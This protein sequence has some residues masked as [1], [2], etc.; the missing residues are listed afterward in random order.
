[1][2]LVIWRLSFLEGDWDLMVS[3]FSHYFFHIIYN[4]TSEA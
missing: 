1:M 2:T 3:K 4:A